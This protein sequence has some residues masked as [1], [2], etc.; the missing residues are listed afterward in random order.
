MMNALLSGSYIAPIV[1]N[2]R[3]LAYFAVICQPAS[4][5]ADYFARSPPTTS[6]VYALVS[7]PP[8]LLPWFPRQTCASGFSLNGLSC[9]SGSGGLALVQFH[10]HP[11]QLAVQLNVAAVSGYLTPVLLLGVDDAIEI[12]LVV[13]GL[14]LAS[15]NSRRFASRN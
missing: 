3:Q 11:Q 5:S 12:E 14:G 2:L 8:T 4:T 13:P 10:M 9:L 7:Q 1:T 6:A 15:T